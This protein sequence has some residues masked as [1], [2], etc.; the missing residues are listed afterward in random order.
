MNGNR[1]V[2]KLWDDVN[3]SK[4]LLEVHNEVVGRMCPGSNFQNHLNG[5]LPSSPGHDVPFP[6]YS[7]A[8]SPH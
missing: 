8:T 7:A 1:I 4:H 6:P 5:H 2:A 3:N